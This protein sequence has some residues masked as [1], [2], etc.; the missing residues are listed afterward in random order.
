[1]PVV[2]AAI[3]SRLGFGF[4]TFCNAVVFGQ[5]AFERFAHADQAEQIRMLDEIQGIDFSDARKRTKAWRDKIV[6][7]MGEIENG[8]RMDSEALIGAR[9][10][11]TTLSMLRDSYENT[12]WLAVSGLKVRMLTAVDATARAEADAKAIDESGRLLAKLRIADA[13]CTELETV[14][15]Q[16]HNDENFKGAMQDEAGRD[17]RKFDDALEV[18]FGNAVCPVCR[19]KVDNAPKIKER[20]AKDRAALS[21]AGV[22]R[23]EFARPRRSSMDRTSAS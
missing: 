11:V 22:R 21:R 14:L 4:R 17:L 2:Q 15:T 10:N 5:G 1:M 23:V 6:V 16:A 8:L 20:F 19:A 9:S 12:K 7:Q 13:K 3:D 18:L